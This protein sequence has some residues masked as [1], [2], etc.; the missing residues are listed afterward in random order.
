MSGFLG[1]LLAGSQLLA[2]FSG[3]RN[4][5]S[6]TAGTYTVSFQLNA[7][8]TTGSS[9]GT[10]SVSSTWINTPYSGVGSLVWVKFGTP[11]GGGTFNL[12]PGTWYSISSGVSANIHNTG[13]GS[14]YFG[15]ISLT[16][17]LDSAGVNQIG[18]GNF[19]YDVGQLH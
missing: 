17:A 16:F 7:D 8:G 14:E 12:T 1:V 9:G 5:T 19:S 18:T 6:S 15:N 11:D 13:T 4:N 10:G 2:S 3:G